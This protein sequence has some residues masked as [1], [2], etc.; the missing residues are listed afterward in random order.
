M[1]DCLYKYR[2]AISSL[3]PSQETGREKA[4]LLHYSFNYSLV[5]YPQLCRVLGNVPALLI[6]V[7]HLLCLIPRDVTQLPPFAFFLLEVLTWPFDQDLTLQFATQCQPVCQ[8]WPTFSVGLGSDSLHDLFLHR[9]S[10]LLPG[11]SRTHLWFVMCKTCFTQQWWIS[12][13]LSIPKRER[14]HSIQH[15]GL[16]F[17]V[18][19]ILS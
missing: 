2:D 13:S 11:F 17:G 16:C 6:P 8:E 1:Q 4:C 9:V 12:D 19:L 7:N 5:H 14:P 18:M 15:L 10:V 3:L